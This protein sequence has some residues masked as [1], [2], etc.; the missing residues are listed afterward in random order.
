LLS[1]EGEDWRTVHHDARYRAVLRD[2]LSDVLKEA[3][4]SDISWKTP[5]QSGYY[6]P[7]VTA[8]V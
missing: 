8:R 7:I 3:G 1:E 2:E 4:F 5:A 6:Q